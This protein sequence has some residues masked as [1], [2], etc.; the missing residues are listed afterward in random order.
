ML[1]YSKRLAEVDEVLNHLD[2]KYLDKIPTDVRQ[3]IT[4]QKDP[5]YLWKYDTTKALKEQNLSRDTIIILTYLNKEYLLDD[6]GRKKLEKILESNEQKYNATLV[7]YNFDEIFK[8][9]SA[10]K[11]TNET[12]SE[13][14]ILEV[15][16]NENLFK[17]FVN[18]IKEVF[19]INKSR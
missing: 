15:R 17:K 14:G 1:D 6:E 18:K 3:A 19:K 9:M 13:E 16:Q 4:S 2:K 12:S 7:D 8:D 5:E 11:E 10:S